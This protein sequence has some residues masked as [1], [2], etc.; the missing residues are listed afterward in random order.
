MGQHSTKKYQMI[1][2]RFSLRTITGSSVDAD[3]SKQTLRASK[4]KIGVALE[5]DDRALQFVSL[6]AFGE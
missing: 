3:S 4:G 6:K 2:E 5:G 1:Q